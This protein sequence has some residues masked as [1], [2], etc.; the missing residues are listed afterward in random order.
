[1]PRLGLNIPV[2][3]MNLRDHRK[4]I[5]ELPSLGYTDVWTGEASGAD[6]FVPLAAGAAWS[7]VLRFGVAVVPVQTRGPAVI[8]QTAASL[9]E[10]APGRV[11]VGIGSSGPRFVTG[12]N[13]IPFDRPYQHVRDTLQFLRRSLDGGI[14]HGA[15]DTFDI[16][17]FQLSRPP[18]I[19]PALMVGALRPR[20]LTLGWQSADG[21]ITNFLSP[22]DVTRVRA[23][24]DPLGPPRELVAR[25][26]VIP[27]ADARIARLLG[28]RLLAPILAAP[29]Y[30]A[31]HTW[32]GR[33][34]RLATSLRRWQ[35]GDYLGAVAAIPDEVTDDLIV[36]GDADACRRRIAEY[37]AAG[38][39][40]PVLMMSGIGE[41]GL[42]PSD[43]WRVIAEMAADT[44]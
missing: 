31:F 6:G 13:G 12:F 36:H 18:A 34:D 7:D 23:V 40:T 14:V 33:A 11:I 44:R 2:P 35:A 16:D 8:A 24:V 37:V 41:L 30:H 19:P 15:F 38:V 29:T 25:L 5:G 20:M 9:A 10:L 4:L 32:L 1:M 3:M 39:D 27:T 22:A 17:S 42:E 28:A 26:F 43:V 21:V